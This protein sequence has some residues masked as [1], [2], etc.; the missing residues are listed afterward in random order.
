MDSTGPDHS[1]T[2]FVHTV[3]RATRT[4]TAEELAT[5]AGISRSSL[6]RL[7]RLGLI[8]PESPGADAFAATSIPRM[9]RMLRLRR[10]LDLDLEAAALVVDLLERMDRLEA[11]LSRM[12]GPRG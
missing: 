4:I 2:V 10:E 1:T 6:G 12:R 9:R 5:A 7:R 11:E 3:V 8:E